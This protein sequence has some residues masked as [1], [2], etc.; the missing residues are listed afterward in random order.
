MGEEDGVTREVSDAAW[1]NRFF[2][3]LGLQLAGTAIALFGLVLWQTDYV[4][5]GGSVWGFA[6][7]LLGLVISFFG[8]RTLARRWKRH[9]R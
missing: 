5:R 9:D 4:V 1:R 3:M 2:L 7:A 6:V 8:P